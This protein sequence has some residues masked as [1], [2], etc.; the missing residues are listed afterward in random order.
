M[1]K[2]LIAQHKISIAYTF[3]QPSEKF[4]PYQSLMMHAKRMAELILPYLVLWQRAITFEKEVDGFRAHE[5]D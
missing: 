5:H 1:I 4:V 2:T 3:I